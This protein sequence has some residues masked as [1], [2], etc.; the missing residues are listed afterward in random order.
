MEFRDS[1]PADCPPAGHEIIAS[2]RPVY[3]LVDHDPPQAIDFRN[4]HEQ[5]PTRKWRN[6]PDPCHLRAVSVWETLDGCRSVH[7]RGPLRIARIILRAGAGAIV[8][9]GRPGHLSW[10]P[11]QAFDIEA[12]AEIVIAEES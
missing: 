7:R 12:N 5:Y 6:N 2:D 4:S 10:W 8:P 9:Y 3:R 1:L 11:S